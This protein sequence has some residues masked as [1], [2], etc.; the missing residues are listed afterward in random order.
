MLMQSPYIKASIW[1][2]GFP[3]LSSIPHNSVIMSVQQMQEEIEAKLGIRL[4]PEEC[5]EDKLRKLRR[6]AN[7]PPDRAL[8][9]AA[10]PLIP[11]HDN[12]QDPR[13]NSPVYLS[14]FYRRKSAGRGRVE[15]NIPPLEAIIDLDHTLVECIW[16]PHPYQK[17]SVEEYRTTILREH[18]QAQIKLITVKQEDQN[19]HMLYTVRPGADSFLRK[20]RR[21]AELTL[22]TRGER[23]YVTELLTLQ[24]WTELF[25]RV[26]C[27]SEDRKSLHASLG[28]TSR[29]RVVIV[30]D[31]LRVWVEE[32]QPYVI[33]VSRYMPLFRFDRKYT[34]NPRAAQNFLT[35]SFATELPDLVEASETEARKSFMD[36]FDST[37]ME[38][39][40]RRL[41]EVHEHMFVR[42]QRAIQSFKALLEREMRGKRFQLRFPKGTE[43]R[44]TIIRWVLGALGARLEAGAEAVTLTLAQVEGWGTPSPFSDIFK[45]Y[46]KSARHPHSNQ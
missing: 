7:E 25:A 39:L 17:A 15:I 42:T 46:F 23:G 32:D 27:V 8:V 38:T 44:E 14:A 20:L 6:L 28:I 21:Y 18:P 40:Q 19:V 35:Y 41:K 29:D 4:A 34:E 24:Q 3:E 2:E 16:P 22:F 30:D 5:A 43:G 45:A 26:V 9:S 13:L 12:L 36:G 1:T 33:P 37:Q 31:Q 11:I 10:I